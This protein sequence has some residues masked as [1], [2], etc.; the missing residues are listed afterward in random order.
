MNMA[1]VV[2]MTVIHIEF[3]DQFVLVGVGNADAEVS[4]HTGTGRGG[5]HR[6]APIAARIANHLNSNRK[7]HGV[8]LAFRCASRSRPNSDSF[9]ARAPD[10]AGGI[11]PSANQPV[12]SF[13]LCLS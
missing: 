1:A 2:E 6:R 8:S 7:R 5:G 11:S 9:A 4:R 12:G 10:R 13:G 3:A